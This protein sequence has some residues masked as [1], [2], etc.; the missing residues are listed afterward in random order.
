M[1]VEALHK[2]AYGRG[3]NQWN[4]LVKSLNGQSGHKHVSFYILKKFNI[5]TLS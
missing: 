1:W 3:R 4:K 2:H 5:S